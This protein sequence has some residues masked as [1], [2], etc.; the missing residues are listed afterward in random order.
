[1]YFVLLSMLAK[2]TMFDAKFSLSHM[3]R[4]TV[5]VTISQIADYAE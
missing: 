1:M 4:L 2:F 5:S 3:N